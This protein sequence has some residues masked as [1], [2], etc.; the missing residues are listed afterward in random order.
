MTPRAYGVAH[1]VRHLAAVTV[2]I[3]AVGAAALFM[4]TRV[5]GS[6]SLLAAMGPDEVAQFASVVAIVTVETS[7]ARAIGG[8]SPRVLTET[9]VRV[10]EVLK[11]DIAPGLLT[12]TTPGGKSGLLVEVAEDAIHLEPGRPLLLFLFRS[13]A[14]GTLS[15]LGG[16]QGRYFV[17]G[18]RTWNEERTSTLSEWRQL[19]TEVP[20]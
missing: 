4:N 14:D 9:G 10:R 19:I 3:F 11:G 1:E 2:L 8:S 7:S 12:I 18:D 16:F 20:R 17:D 15:I 13:P 6:H 5:I